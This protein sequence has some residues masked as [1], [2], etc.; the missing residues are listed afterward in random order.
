MN[1][2]VSPEQRH[3]FPPDEVIPTAGSLTKAQELE[4]DRR[5]AQGLENATQIREAIGASALNYSSERPETWLEES[6]LVDSRGNKLVYE[7]AEPQS[8]EKGKRRKPL[9]RSKLSGRG[10]LLADEPTVPQ[11]P[12]N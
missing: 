10:K 12:Y 3:L 11:P 2:S 4:F 8:N 1:R 7:V 9:P 6:D 5:D